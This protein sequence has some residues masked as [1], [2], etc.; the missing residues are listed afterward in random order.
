MIKENYKIKIIEDDLFIHNTEG[1]L[2]YIGDANNDINLK[3][4]VSHLNEL[5]NE[6]YKAKTEFG[7]QI[8]KCT[9][10]DTKLDF[11]INLLFDINCNVDVHYNELLGMKLGKAER[12]GFNIEPSKTWDY[13]ESSY[14][15]WR[16]CEDED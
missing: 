3:G 10:L 4:I 7:Y 16:N 14:E 13:D 2:W 12:L 15:F 8:I 5:S 1:G 6:L 11:L 9:D